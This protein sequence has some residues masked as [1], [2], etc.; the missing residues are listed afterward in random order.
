VDL[1]V[2]V[3]RH[4]PEW[5]RL[6]QLTNRAGRPSRLSGA[7]LDELV[8]LYQ[9]AAT[10]LS[11]IRTR[12]PDPALLDSLSGLVTSARQVLSGARSPGWRQ[13]IRFFGVT[14]PVAVWERRW[15]LL[16]TSL[17]CCAVSL[18]L[19]VWV[20]TDRHVAGALL[21]PEQVQRLCGSEFSDYYRSAPAGSFAGQVWTNNLWV[22]ATAVA[23]GVLLGIPTVFVLGYNAVN[24]GIS[25]GYLASCG[26]TAEFFTLILPHGL[27]ELTAVFL[28][29]ATGLRLGW[30]VVAPGPR[31]RIDAVAAEAGPP[32]LSRWG[33]SSCWRSAGCWRRS[34]PP[35]RCRRPCGW[36]PEPWYGRPCWVTCCCAGGRRWG[37]PVPV[38]GAVLAGPTWPTWPTLPTS[39][40]T[41]RS[42]RCLSACEWT[43]DAPTEALVVAVRRPIARAVLLL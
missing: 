43:A 32:S 25:G 16:W 12:S 17:A 19:G 14:F 9:R 23:F 4:R 35:R 18:A 20:A 15:W 38:T 39:P 3:T 8:D 41:S 40:T 26:R 11:A 27:L 6:E 22:A 1:D 24:V 28:A 42:T 37:R 29:G 21:Q 2:F 10:H 7:E 33:S 31:R 13:V 5:Q 34:S 30:R 36:R